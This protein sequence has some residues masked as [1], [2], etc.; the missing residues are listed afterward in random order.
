MDERDPD[1][2]FPAKRFGFGWGLPVTWQGWAVV[3]VY[4]VMIAIGVAR[5]RPDDGPVVTFAWFAGWT[6]ALMAVCWLKG[7]PLR[8]R[9]NGR[10]RH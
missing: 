1:I 10:P 9:W 7:E 4:G 2:W 5:I 8:W 6:L 3:A